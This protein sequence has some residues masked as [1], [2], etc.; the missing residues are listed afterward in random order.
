MFI[1][2]ACNHLYYVHRHD[3]ITLRSSA[4]TGAALTPAPVTVALGQR[5]QR[6]GGGHR[7]RAG[8][9]L[10]VGR[11]AL[12]GTPATPVPTIVPDR[13]PCRGGGHRQTRARPAHPAT[14]DARSTLTR[15]WATSHCAFLRRRGHRRCRPFSGPREAVAVRPQCR[16]E[17][18]GTRWPKTVR[19]R[20]VRRAQ[21]CSLSRNGRSSRLSR[22]TWA[23]AAAAR[24]W[25]GR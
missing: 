7:R 2:S 14:G 1:Y 25:A 19:G 5:R 3:G 18:P 4:T 15:G 17:V 9:H 11:P 21:S 13:P 12:A 22:S 8:L 20:P 16:P 23:R 24:W 6:R 10:H